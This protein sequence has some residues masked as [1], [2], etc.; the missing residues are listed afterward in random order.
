[1]PPE[2]ATELSEEMPKAK[3]EVADFL[4]DLGEEMDEEWELI[5]ARRV[6]YDEEE[7]M[8]ALWT[9]ARAVPSG[10]PQAVAPRTGQRT[11]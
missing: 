7:K 1:M 6:D 8:D 5:D 11:Y 10:K 9:F 2:E 4:I 3:A